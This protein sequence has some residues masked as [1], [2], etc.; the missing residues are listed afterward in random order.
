MENK[1]IISV[2]LDIMHGKVAGNYSTAEATES[3]R[4]ALIEAN[5]GSNKINPKTFHRG[6]ELFALVEELIPAIIEEGLSEDNKLFDLVE[7][8]NIA[9][10][11]ENAFVTEGEATFVVADTAA[12]IQGVRRQRIEGGE[13]V[14]VKTSMKMVRVYEG[15]NRLLAGRI[16]FDKFVDGV[17]K[18]FKQQILKDAYNCINNMTA[19][20]KGLNST[21]VKSGSFD[22]ATLVKLVEDVEVATGKVAR[23][24]GTKTA[25]RKI[26]SAVVADSAK[27]DMYNLGYYGKFN[28]TEMFALKQA[29]NADGSQILNNSKVFIIAGDDKPVKMVNEGEGYMALKEAANNNDLTQEYVYGQAY[30]TGVIC[31]EKMGIYTIS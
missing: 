1:D 13:V 18:A 9:A 20:T 28:G 30:G 4:A 25:L 11:D 27:E 31:A 5:G 14:T 22:E 26:S 3:L 29:H 2:A 12:G 17:A 19:S 23:I 7:Y 16:S 21:Y 10:G 8:K 6:N 15:L 24:Y